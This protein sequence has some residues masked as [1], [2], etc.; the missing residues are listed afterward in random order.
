MLKSKV[1]YSTNE[2]YYEMG[3]ET[4]KE[5]TKDFS[6]VRLNFLYTSEKCDIKKLLKELEM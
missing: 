6:N 2:D 3:F 4:A 1:G 5:S